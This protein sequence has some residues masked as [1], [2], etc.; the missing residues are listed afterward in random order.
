MQLPPDLINQLLN[1]AEDN[2]TQVIPTDL[3]ELAAQ[4]G[5]VPGGGGINNGQFLQLLLLQQAEQI[6]SDLES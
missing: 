3:L 4:L 5:V 6:I 2:G 1:A